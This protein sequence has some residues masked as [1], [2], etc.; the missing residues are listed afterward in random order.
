MTPLDDSAQSL[1]N[2]ERALLQRLSPLLDALEADERLQRRLSELISSLDALFLLVIAG[3]FNAGKSTLVNALF[4]ER[5]MEE[6]PVPTTDRITVLRYGDTAEVHRKGEFVTERTLPMPLLRHLA[7]VD[8]PGT[9]SII[10]EHQR[11]TED[12]VPRADLV[13]FVTSYDRPLS[14][15]ER[16]FL[17]YIQ[18]AWGKRLVVVVNKADL[19]EDEAALEQV[20]SHVSQAVSVQTGREPQLFPLSARK[21]LLA[22]LDHLESPEAVH[23]DPRW[24]ASRFAPFESFLTDTL[25]DA[26]R[27]AL[28]LTGP[29]DAAASLLTQAEDRLEERATVVHRDQKALDDLHG[30]FRETEAVLEEVTGR[31]VSEVDRE[32]LE[33]ERRGV[34]FL[35][36]TIR[37]SRLGLLRNRDAFKEE[38]SRQVLRDAEHRIEERAGEAAD[39]L[40]RHVFDLWNTVYARLAEL[41]GPGDAP[42][43]DSFLYDREA[44]LRDVMREARRIID[45]VDLDEEAR[46]LLEN[47]RGAAA[48]FAGAQAAAV[49]LGAIAAVVV[50]A[51]AF[52]VTG[53]FVAAGALAA[54]GFVILPRHRKRAVR[55][56][57]ERVEEL[58]QDLRRAL[59]TEFEKEAEDAV[60]RVR[61]LIHPMETLVAEQEEAL[62]AHRDIAEEARA[63][64]NHLRSTVRERYGEPLQG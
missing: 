29:L 22:R 17:D 13:L 47:A 30:R 2:R 62:T 42:P 48:L 43:S 64:L 16:Q 23:T 52:D 37:V 11:L 56:F 59:E 54:L 35:E 21:A 25:S 9:N 27:L 12:F 7:L 26:D 6:G 1:L 19:A 36:D 15:S 34:R 33:M 53:G 40:L 10:Q 60:R 32:L 51:T 14:E 58:R 20:L 46:R 8:T 3:E 55:E 5:V 45:T 38:F 24:Q 28:K 44:V 57:A 18:G 31:A 49:G 41:R 39:A 61:T 4:G 63:E 50:A